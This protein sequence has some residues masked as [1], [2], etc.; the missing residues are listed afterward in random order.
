VA[1]DLLM[2]QHALFAACLLA[3]A[4]TVTAPDEDP[5][6][7][8]DGSGGTDMPTPDSDSDSDPDPDPDPDPGA[9]GCP[10]DDLG[11][12]DG[13]KDPSATIDRMDP[14]DPESPAVRQ[15][16]GLA[17][18]DV[19]FELGLWDGYGAFADSPAAPGDYPI[20]GDEADP[21]NCGLCVELRMT[22][23]ESAKAP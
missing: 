11:T 22:A 18:P 8:D 16:T 9:D 14:E 10:A 2:T 5:I 4:C 13:L 19:V 17:A 12:V 23:G 21:D 1:L 20:S 15:L 7:G 6:T 3:A